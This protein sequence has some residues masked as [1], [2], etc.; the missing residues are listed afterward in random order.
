MPG[1]LDLLFPVACPLCQR[2]DKG[3]E[4]KKQ[5][6]C[7]DCYKEYIYPINQANVLTPDFI[8]SVSQVVCCS[9]Y[10][11]K[12]RDA[13]QR[14][15]FNGETYIGKE[16]GKIAYSVLKKTNCLENTDVVTTVPIS[17]SRFKE[18]GYNQSY[19]IAKE[20][21]ALSGCR[22]EELLIRNIQGEAQSHLL[23]KDR[24]KAAGERFAP[25]ADI[26]IQGKSILLI[27][28]ILTSGSTLDQCG[29]I[30]KDAGALYITALCITSGRKE[31]LS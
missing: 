24:E 22:Y 1:I 6:A 5:G 27:D 13:M 16:F 2:L 30:L 19:L 18:R 3:Q 9:G 17:D 15:K 23:L 7:N 20:L 10:T 14:F 29:K 25:V 12:M 4:V 11:G 8:P 21:C 28:D 26:D 31:F